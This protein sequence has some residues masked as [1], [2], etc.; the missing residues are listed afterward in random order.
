MTAS[1]DKSLDG[2]NAN[3]PAL[4]ETGPSGGV[5][6]FLSVAGGKPDAEIRPGVSDR[7]FSITAPMPR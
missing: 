3:T 2:E 5:E 6:P 7:A 1:T 4:V